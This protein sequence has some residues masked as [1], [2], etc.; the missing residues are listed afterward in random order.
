V[1]GEDITPAYV[2]KVADEETDRLRAEFG[3]EIYESGRFDEARQI[4]EQVALADDFP[5]FLTLPAYEILETGAEA[6]PRADGEGT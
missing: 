3:H 4:L 1:E 6:T 5:E 2:M